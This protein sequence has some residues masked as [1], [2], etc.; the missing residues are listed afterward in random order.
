MELIT[1]NTVTDKLWENE[2]DF[3]DWI[4]GEYGCRIIRHPHFKHLCGY[5]GVNKDH[6]LYGMS[7][8]SINDLY[9]D[10]NVHGG[11]TYS[12]L[13]ISEELPTSE[14]WWIGFD[15]GHCH[16]FQPGYIELLKNRGVISLAMSDTVYRT[17]DYVKENVTKL[18]K[19]LRESED[20]VSFMVGY[21]KGLITKLK[22]DVGDR[23]LTVCKLVMKELDE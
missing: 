15:C 21:T 16:D 18:V 14:L 4:D 7:Y 13:F 17:I 20:S 9:P 8:D 12:D 2:P 19:Q 23:A 10:L 11:L 1:N 6:V 5:V 22:D 3:L